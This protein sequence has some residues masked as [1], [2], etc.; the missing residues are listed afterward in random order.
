MKII[1]ALRVA[2]L[3]KLMIGQFF[4]SPKR[5]ASRL[6]FRFIRIPIGIMINPT[7]INTGKT[8]YIK[9]PMYVPP[10][11]KTQFRITN[12]KIVARLKIAKT[13]PE[14]ETPVFN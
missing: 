3:L 11:L 7:I 5:M 13:A 14:I 12:E 2:I 6:A 9:I 4:S 8:M 10:K 1:A